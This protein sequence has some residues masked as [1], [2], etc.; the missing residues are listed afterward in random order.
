MRRVSG[1][2]GRHAHCGG[3]AAAGPAGPRHREDRVPRGPRPVWGI[4]GSGFF[5]RSVGSLGGW[6]EWV[7]PLGS[8]P[9]APLE[10]EG[11][12][13]VLRNTPSLW[14]GGGEELRGDSVAEGSGVIRLTEWRVG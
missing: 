14:G 9:P 12:G 7:G 13:W 2:V 10:G 5:S 8:P 4:M 6:G 1:V 11:C 3:D